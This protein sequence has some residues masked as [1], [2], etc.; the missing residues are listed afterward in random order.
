MPGGLVHI[1]TGNGKGKTTAALGLCFRAAGHG[2]RCAF[3]QFLKGRET[4]EMFS[5]SR[6]DPAIIF[7]QYGSRD[8][9]TGKSSETLEKQREY[10]EKGFARAREL[11]SDGKFDIVVLDEIITLPVLKICGEERIVQ[12][13]GIDRGKTELVLT[14][15]G[16]GVE[17]IRRADLVTEMKEIKHYYASGIPARKGVE[18]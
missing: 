2:F 16:A 14:G 4:G 18:Y 3:I 12:L 5:C 17:L 7:E 8:F 1:Y 9:V 11:I 6:I 15:R 10:A 13:L